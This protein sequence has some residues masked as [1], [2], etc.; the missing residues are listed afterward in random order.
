MKQAAF[1]ISLIFIVAL[2][3]GCQ[4]EKE[5]IMPIGGDAEVP[6]DIAKNTQESPADMVVMIAIKDFAFEPAELKIKK[7]EAVGWQ[8]YDS[9]PHDVTSTT[10]SELASGRLQTG[11]EY[12]HVFNESGIFGYYCTIHPYMKAKIVVVQ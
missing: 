9:A 4:K 11:D 7:G 5:P 3:F 8:N 2:L 12:Q 1:F 6:S 10:G